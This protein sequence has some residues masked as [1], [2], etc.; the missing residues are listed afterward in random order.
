MYF[1]IYIC[2]CIHLCKWISFWGRHYSSPAQKP[3]LPLFLFIEWEFCSVQATDALVSRNGS[4]FWLKHGDQLLPW[5]LV[6]RYGLDSAS[7]FWPI[8]FL[9]QSSFLVTWRHHEGRR[10]CPT[11]PICP[12]IERGWV[13]A[14]CL[15]AAAAFL[16]QRG[17]RPR[18]SKRWPPRALRSLSY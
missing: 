3:L 7:S 11:L 9:E 17:R 4:S 10:S 1:N 2:V 15:R 5:T 18:T 8:R 13:R 12:T 16:K 14:K 6:P